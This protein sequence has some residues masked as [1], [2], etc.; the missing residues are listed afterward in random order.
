MRAV[1]RLTAGL[2]RSRWGSSGKHAAMNGW[3]ASIQPPGLMKMRCIMKSKG[4][5]STPRKARLEQERRRDVERQ[6]GGVGVIGVVVVVEERQRRA[7]LVQAKAALLAA[8]I[9][10]RAG[11]LLPAPPQPCTGKPLKPS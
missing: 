11:L 10:A 3:V 6:A 2:A 8:A 1:T 7:V 4:A 9:V 5:R